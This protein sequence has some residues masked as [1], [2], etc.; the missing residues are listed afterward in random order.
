M[1][2]I[3][4]GYL[5]P[6]SDMAGNPIDIG[7][8]S[9]M[10]GKAERILAHTR[11]GRRFVSTVWIGLEFQRF[12]T[13]VFFTLRG[14][15][16]SGSTALDQIRYVTAAQALRGHERIVCDVKARARIYR[17]PGRRTD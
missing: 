10:F 12:E 13:M 15:R 3:P 2:L 8:W 9:T 16:W 6:Y 7:E 11:V 1:E 14:R 17:A 4:P 5:S